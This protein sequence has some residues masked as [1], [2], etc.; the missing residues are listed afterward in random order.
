MEKQDQNYFD[1]SRPLTPKPAVTGFGHTSIS[2]RT[3]DF[4]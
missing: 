2:N 4:E 3:Y 1:I